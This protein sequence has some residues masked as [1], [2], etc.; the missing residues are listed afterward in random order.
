MSIAR[1]ILKLAV[2]GLVVP[3]MSVSAGV[4]NGNVSLNGTEATMSPRFFRSGTP[5][6]SCSTFSSGNFQHRTVSFRTDGSGTLAAAVDPQTCGTG[7]F[8]TFHLG[9][10]NPTSICEGHHWSFGS[11]QAYS[12]SFTVPPNTDMTMVVSG[13]AN[14]PGVNCGPVAYTLNGT[15]T[16]APEPE[17]EPPAPPEPVPSLPVPGALPGT[18]DAN[19][20]GVP[21]ESQ[22]A[23][24][25][26]RVPSLPGRSLTWMTLVA[27]GTDGKARSSQ[28]I[29]NDLWQ[30]EDS[31]GL[32]P[33][34]ANPP[35]Y[36]GHLWFKASTS[37]PG[38]QQ[39]FSLYVDGS[40]AP[41]G[42]WVRNRA[43]TW[44]NL[45]SAAYGGRVVTEGGRFRLDIVI[46]DG[47]EF[48][49]DNS[50]NGSVTL[51]GVVGNRP[52]SVSQQRPQLPAGGLAL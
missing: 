15:G 40:M 2:T 17:P 5:G 10:F 13:V 8:V 48:D 42:W 24:Q 20:D 33:N 43:G 32:P 1:G 47:G 19:G 7:V 46:Q 30:D 50:S 28:A 34:L 12:T 22:P 31:Q 36:L 14:A 37:V 18:G 52:Q 41:N 26:R 27:G 49:V 4:T 3:V 6:A 25:S 38:A 23:V 44:V 35:G 39:T 29:V 51:T 21:D 11:S 45:A 9:N 16:I